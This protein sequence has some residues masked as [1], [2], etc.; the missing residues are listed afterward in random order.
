MNQIFIAQFQIDFKV[1]KS[2][3][4]NY[5][6]S[7]IRED[8]WTSFAMLSFISGGMTLK[9]SASDRRYTVTNVFLATRQMI[10]RAHRISNDSI[11]FFFLSKLKLSVLLLSST[12]AKNKHFLVL[13]CKY[14]DIEFR[15]TIFAFQLRH[16]NVILIV[17]F[18][19]ISFVLVFFQCSEHSIRHVV[20]KQ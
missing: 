10:F 3:T 11:K 14:C 6:A 20:S 18:C 9:L 8:G 19:S 7:S 1:K 13:L 2:E 16:E 5:W 17:S 12:F 4:F 15:Y